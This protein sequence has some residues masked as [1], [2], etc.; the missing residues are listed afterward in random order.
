MDE[1]YP[2]E[3]AIFVLKQ[4]AKLGPFDMETL[5]DGLEEGKFS[6]DDICLR[7]GAIECERLKDILDWE[8]AH[9]SRDVRPSRGNHRA[10][11]PI[12][13]IIDDD[14]GNEDEHFLDGERLLYAG[15]P[16]IASSPLG[17][18]F[19][20]GGIT[21]GVWLYVID[22]VF[23]LAGV[24]LSLLGMAYLSFMRFTQDYRITPRRIEVTTGFLARSSN[25]VRIEDIR[26]INVTC[27]GFTGIIG[28]GTVDFF[29]AGDAAEV[30]FR[31]IWAAQKVKTLVR[32]L[33][34]TF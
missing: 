15:H 2:V 21:G 10:A 22:P 4:G 8:T 16:S 31:K 23:T 11:P 25:E 12:E 28:I 1:N 24:G 33:Q 13:S 5:F 7:E 9:P 29:T 26:A 18:F 30:S 27:R 32:R 19:V 3:E 6:Y 20:V 14:E 34:D 17:L